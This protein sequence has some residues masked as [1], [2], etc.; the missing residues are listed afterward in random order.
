MVE[1]MRKKSAQPCAKVST[2]ILSLLLVCAIVCE[3]KFSLRNPEEILAIQRKSWR[4][5]ISKG[6][7]RIYSDGS[8][9]HIQPQ[10]FKPLKPF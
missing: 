5:E 7:S 9:Y 8:G 10:N 1:V 2:A 3:L 4:I 6:P